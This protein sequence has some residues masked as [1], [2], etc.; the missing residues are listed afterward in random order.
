MILV[1][2]QLNSM[3]FQPEYTHP[4]RVDQLFSIDVRSLAALRLGMAILILFDIFSN[5]L[6]HVETF[7]SRAGIL[8]AELARE[9]LGPG[10]WSIYWQVD[11]ISTIQTLLLV[12]AFAALCLL[13]GFQTRIA[14]AVCLVLIWSLQVCNPLVLNGGDI[15]LRMLLFWSIFLPLGAVWSVDER[16]S[17]YDRPSRFC[18][19]SVASAAIM[20]QVAAMYFFSGLAKCNDYWTS[21][22][23]V[24]YALHLEMYVKPAGVWLSERSE[25]TSI[26]TWAVLVIELLGPPLLFLPYGLRFMRGSLMGVFWMM[27]AAIWMTMSVGMFSAI[28]ML[29]WVV[30]LPP[31]SWHFFLGIRE[32]YDQVYQS[33]SPV[34]N[35]IGS[36]VCGMALILVIAQYGLSF[37]G[38]KS[39]L[40][41]VVERVARVTMCVQEFKLWGE[42]ATESPSFD[43]PAILKNGDE[44]N[45]FFR[46]E[47]RPQQV[48]RQFP[49]HHWRRVHSKLLEGREPVS[50]IY[51]K[52]RRQFLSWLVRRWDETQTQQE[53][54]ETATLICFEKPILYGDGLGAAQQSVLCEYENTKED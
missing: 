40:R 14:T 4:R 7:Y 37:Q 48:Y 24:E 5:R 17:K 21:G 53:N 42:P 36:I 11:Q 8:P 41:S 27:H 33:D 45:L 46:F 16:L 31:Q 9:F 30:F 49:S 35:T 52:L 32:D 10:Y 34:W 43:Y 2:A 23:A 50:A 1:I 22:Q 19:T 28:A 13:V 44:V 51:H 26:A 12:N 47:E 25:L 20:L 29:S 3:N 54:V 38:D 39:E 18:E 6:S 15:L